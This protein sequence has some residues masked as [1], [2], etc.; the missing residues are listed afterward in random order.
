MIA[1]LHQQRVAG[2]RA[3]GGERRQ[4]APIHEDAGVRHVFG[5]I[6][7]LGVQIGEEQA[8]AFHLCV[9][10]VLAIAVEEGGRVEY[11]PGGGHLDGGNGRICAGGPTGEEPDEHAHALH[12][13]S[14]VSADVVEGIRARG[15]LGQSAQRLSLINDV[16]GLVDQTGL[17]L[18]GIMGLYALRNA[19]VVNAPLTKKIE[20]WTSI[21][22]GVLL[23]IMG[24]AGSAVILGIVLGLALIG[25]GFQQ[26]RLASS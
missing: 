18:S 25:I 1:L 24:A 17:I 19:S 12:D 13:A 15:R 14:H 16:E 26:W 22:L 5:S 8:L 2:I 7:A 23:V 11:V 9:E 21:A 20:Y 4:P 6:L 10:A 3:V